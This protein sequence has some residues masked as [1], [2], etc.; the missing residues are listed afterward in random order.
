MGSNGS[1]RRDIVDNDPCKKFVDSGETV[2]RVA[3]KIK[4]NFGEKAKLAGM[5]YGRS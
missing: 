5:K 3:K 1:V 2:V 4:I